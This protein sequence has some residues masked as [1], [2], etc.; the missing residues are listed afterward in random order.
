MSILSIFGSIVSVFTGTKLDLAK[1]SA[2]LL[3]DWGSVIG[4][5]Q[6]AETV[7]PIVGLPEV[8]AVLKVTIAALTPLINLIAAGGVGNATQIAT[9]SN[10][11]QTLYRLSIKHVRVIPSV[12]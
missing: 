3:E 5:A 12:A 6:I 7:T 8:A 1:A 4:I 2:D 9:A 10:T 11:L